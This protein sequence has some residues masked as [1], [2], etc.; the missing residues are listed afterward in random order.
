M[1]YA[2]INAGVVAKYPYSL[3]QLRMDN[4]DTSYPREEGNWLF[5]HGV[6]VVV[7]AISPTPAL[8]ENV[9]EVTPILIGE[10]W[11][12][13]WQLV[14]ASAEEIAKRQESAAQDAARGTVKADT[15]V[16]SFIAMTPAEVS[17]Y[18]TNNGTTLA[19]LRTIVIKLAIMVLILAKREFR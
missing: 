15:F 8:T 11:T 2:L 5:D 19:A 16:Q 7:D 17:T 1:K 10:N 14:L 13:A 12:Q 9:V 4:P 6:H 18:I 3:A